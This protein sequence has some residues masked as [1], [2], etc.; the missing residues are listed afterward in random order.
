MEDLKRDK[1]VLRDFLKTKD[2]TISELKAKLESQK[3]QITTLQ[4]QRDQMKQR[5]EF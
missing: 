3:L 4:Q 2:Q 5:I 1:S